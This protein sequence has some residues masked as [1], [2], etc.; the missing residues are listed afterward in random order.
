MQ[1]SIAGLPSLTTSEGTAGEGN[2]GE[3]NAGEVMAQLYASRK[4]VPIN[5]SLSCIGRD[6][7]DTSRASPSC[8]ASGVSSL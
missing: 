2:A 5:C 4:Y 8:D 7:V 1:D 3:G 6:S